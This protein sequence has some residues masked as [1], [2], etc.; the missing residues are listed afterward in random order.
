MIQSPRSMERQ[1]AALAWPVL[2]Q[3]MLIF[4]VGQYDRFLAGHFDPP[5]G[6]S[7]VAF[8]AAQTTANYL[9]WFISCFSAL[10]SVGSTALVARFTGEGSARDVN[11][12][13]HQSIILALAIG[14][15]GSVAGG[16]STS[17]IVGWVGLEGNSAGI[18]SEFLT[19][20]LG[21]L[22]FQVI[23]LAGIACLIGAGDTKTGLRVLGGVALLNMPMAY[24]GRELFGFPGIAMGTA[25]SHLI[26]GVAV[27]VILSRGQAGLKLERAKLR[28][29]LDLMRRLL[30]VS[31]PASIDTLSVGLCQLWFL[32][33]V[34]ALGDVSATAHGIA[35]GWEGLGYMSGQAVATAATALVGQNWGR[36][37]RRRP[38]APAGPPSASGRRSCRSWASSFMC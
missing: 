21:L 33:M 4:L 6:V 3:Q 36:A 13:L 38:S 7:H 16:L 37:G 26:G 18:A 25:I 23:E 11:R 20:I 19:P 17:T 30:R 35:I 5:P 12:T 28:P 27:L 10:V 8:Q 29:D 24:L 2:I 34:N 1:I 31:V 14:V 32:S 9:A 22:V 15:G